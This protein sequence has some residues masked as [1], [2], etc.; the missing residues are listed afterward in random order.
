L[1]NGDKIVAVDNSPYAPALYFADKRYTVPRIDDVSYI[2]VIADICRS[3][4]IHAIMTLIDPE[5]EIMSRNSELFKDVGV[6]V[7]TPC[8]RTASLCY[9]KY[10]FYKHLKKYG[11]DTPDTW[12]CLD[13]FEQ[14]LSEGAVSFPVFIKPRMGS[15]SIGA[16]KVKSI[17]E[18]ENA[19]SENG[20][21]IIQE[22]MDC[23]DIDADVYVDVISQKAVSVFTKKKIETRIGGA[24]KT[25]SFK[26]M[27]LFDIIQKAVACF[28]LNGPTDM[29]FFCRDGRYY[30]SEINPRFGGGYLHA[31]AS[32]VDFFK[33]VRNNL[34][35]IE[36]QPSLGGYEEDVVMMM[37]D[38]V[39]IAKRGKNNNGN[40][41][42]IFGG[43]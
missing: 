35:G 9:D 37:Y 8:V 2:G 29:D 14:S 32:G 34:N 27:A 38:S 24:S 23:A 25:V 11:I 13:G 39:V 33:L 19:V 4:N 12:D 36:N 31:Y 18:L 43:V 16:R 21:L 1:D 40:P 15:G 3:E 17:D 28:E 10:L 26:D 20:R 30:L 7:I 6:N 42:E 41:L 22:F 5:I